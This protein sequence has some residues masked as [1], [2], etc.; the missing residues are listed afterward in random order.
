MW[1]GGD[2]KGDLEMKWKPVETSDTSGSL[3]ATLLHLENR[4]V[5]SNKFQVHTHQS[6]V[7]VHSCL[8][9]KRERF[10]GLG[11]SVC[12]QTRKQACLHL[13][14]DLVCPKVYIWAYW[15]PSQNV[16]RCYRHPGWGE[17]I[18][19][20][21]PIFPFSVHPPKTVA[22]AHFVASKCDTHFVC[23]E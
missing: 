13:T 7:V 20:P 23:L 18:F 2:S 22:I 5:K 11:L 10:G 12:P 3:T 21:K 17:S 16:Q 15:F 8:T 1:N 4:L 19:P 14:D 9:N 6:S